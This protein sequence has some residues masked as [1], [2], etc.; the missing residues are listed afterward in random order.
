VMSSASYYAHGPQIFWRILV[1][2][3]WWVTQFYYRR[4]L[5]YR[6]SLIYSN[7]YHIKINNYLSFLYI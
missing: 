1:T 5:C 4:C 2:N 6:Y 7:I 3:A